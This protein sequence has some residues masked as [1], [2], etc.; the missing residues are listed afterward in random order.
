MRLLGDEMLCWSDLDGEHGPGPVR[1]AVL[2]PL[3]AAAYGRT[4][5]AGPHDPALTDRISTGDLSLLIRGVADGE[6]LAARYP[7]AAVHC[8]SLGRFRP[9]ERFDTIVALDGLERLGSAEGAELG[10]GRTLDLLLDLLRPGGLLLLGVE[11]FLGLHRLITLPPAVTDSDFAPP[12]EDD[13]TRPAGLSRVRERLGLPV[14]R[15]YSAYPSPQA[16]TALLDT[17]RLSREDQA[18]ALA[19]ACA[20][21]D[22]VLMDPR[23]IAAVAA[24][25][26][27][28]AELAPAW[29]LTTQ[30]IAVPFS[31]PEVVEHR[32]HAVRELIIERD[33]LAQELAEARAKHLWYEQM[34]VNRET[35]LKRARL[36]ATTPGQALLGGAR[37]AKRVLRRVRPRG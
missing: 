10:W 5:V 1:G 33:R 3:P 18:A 36:A 21:V 9:A 2:Q 16:P 15:V 26:G 20:T 17:A 32:P 11:N 23:R 7:E 8:G 14:A 27:A 30:D 13:P 35:A 22:D 12:A 24:R 37:A 29:I 28:A 31:L 34:L 4:L 25:H 19:R 6:A